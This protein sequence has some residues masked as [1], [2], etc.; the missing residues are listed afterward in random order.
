[1]AARK[2]IHERPPFVAWM[3]M[4]YDW[5]VHCPPCAEM[6]DQRFHDCP[7]Y[8]EMA[9]RKLIH[10]CQPFVEM[11]DQKLIHDCPPF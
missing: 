8:V 3:Q 10:D 2:L 11:A 9:A 1:M 7:P 6:A 4:I 5:G